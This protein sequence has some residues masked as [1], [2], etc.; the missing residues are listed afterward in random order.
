MQRMQTTRKELQGERQRDLQDQDLIFSLDYENSVLTQ[1]TQLF[2]EILWI[3]KPI[4]NIGETILYF[5]IY[6]LV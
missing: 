5:L 6:F 4:A 3:Q 1:V 2:L